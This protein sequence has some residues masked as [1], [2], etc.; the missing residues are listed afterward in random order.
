MKAADSP[1]RE[2]LYIPTGLRPLDEILG[3]GIRLRRIT[4][5]SGQHST[6]KTTIAYMAIAEAQKMGFKTI[7]FDTEKR[8]EYDFAEKQ[9]VDLDKLEIDYEKN[10]EELFDASEEWTRKNE[11][12]LVIDS[13]GGLRTRKEEEAKNEATFP[14]APKL[15]P[16]FVRRLQ[17]NLSKNQTAAL[18]LNHEKV[19]FNGKIKVLGG[20]AIPFHSTNWVRFRH[21]PN[22]KLM[23]G[24]EQ[25][26]VVVEATIWKGMN[27]KKTCQLQQIT[28]E[29]FNKQS[30]IM[31]EALER[32]IITKEGQSFVFEG[33]KV[34]RGMSA[35]REK[36]K[37]T[38][39]AAKVHEALENTA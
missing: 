15:I 22:K 23:R 26:G 27:Y 19:D 3:G 9:G 6:G 28:G 10:A 21:L 5:F 36:F 25:V 2:S 11:G 4:Q 18:L 13:I 32:G 33:E 17:N 14:D 1:L 12:L 34:A 35:L 20:E 7:W 24:D 38:S 8:F 39:F 31:D 30:D 16:A 37:E 29:G